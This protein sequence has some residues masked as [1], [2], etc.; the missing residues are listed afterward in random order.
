MSQPLSGKLSRRESQIMNVIY[1]LGRATAEDVRANLPDPPTNSSVRVLLR[2][3]EEKGHIKHEQEGPR[4]VY[5]PTVSP[6]KAGHSALRQLTK[7][8]FGNSVPDVV[9]ALLS[10]S[11]ADLSQ[12]ELDELSRLINQA[13]KEGR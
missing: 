11:R 7:T 9:A 2:I 6:D 13:K 1:Q 12:E 8:F 3:L 4:F 5:F 10:M